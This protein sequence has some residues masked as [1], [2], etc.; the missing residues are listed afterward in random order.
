[1]FLPLILA[2][3]T[4][5]PFFLMQAT[6]GASPWW[7]IPVIQD[8]L[9]D[10]HMYLTWVGYV[11]AGIPFANN[12]GW[13]STCLRVIQS[14]FGGSLS[15]AELWLISR[16]LAALLS[17]YA[18]YF[19]FRTGLT[20]EKRAAS[21]FALAWGLAVISNAGW[22]PG[23]YSWYL[24]FA[25]LACQGILS[26][27][28]TQG[29]VKQGLVLLGSIVLASIY[30]WFLIPIGL[31][32]AVEIARNLFRRTRTWAL[33]W[34]ALTLASLGS[35]FVIMH[36]I[37]WAR[38][39]TTLD[40]FMRYGVG[41][42]HL[43]FLTTAAL[44]P[45]GWLGITVLQGRTT[46]Q[47]SQ[48]LLALYSGWLVTFFCF[49]MTPFTGIVFQNDHFRG[50]VLLL[51]W[52]HLGFLYKTHVSPSQKPSPSTRVL[53]GG[54]FFLSLA[55]SVWKATLF[56]F[57]PSDD[58]SIIQVAYWVPLTLASFL[59][60]ASGYKRLVPYIGVGIFCVLAT[61][62][63]VNIY[64]RHFHH[65]ED[66]E[67]RAH[68]RELVL[69]HVPL[70]DR[71]CIDPVRGSPIAANTPRVL[72]PSS[73]YR[74]RAEAEAEQITLLQA[75]TLGFMAQKDAHEESHLRAIIAQDQAL[76]CQQYR[77]ARSLFTRFGMTE[78]RANALIGCPAARLATLSQF[79]F[80][81]SSIPSST[82]R[83][84]FQRA[85]PWIIVMPGL[86]YLWNVPKDSIWYTTPE[87]AALIKNGLS[88][89]TK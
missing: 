26:I 28:S 29:L 80:D 68:I 71:I 1:M 48:H 11:Q 3:Y 78:A 61:V 25:I 41:F 50:F 58:L 67:L 55:V 37:P 81:H 63:S 52:I 72:L 13:Y 45:L 76:P 59:M 31:W 39:Q 64:G 75:Y 79:V 65:P 36:S 4:L 74:F 82:H 62:A 19:I 22:R 7:R 14:I 8:A 70:E 23:A 20:L 57:A 44:V 87:G 6:W 56:L 2:I 43:P 18:M 33:A 5:V 66:L 83:Q 54:I 51:T 32:G 9:F 49:E 53:L 42:T 46:T 24:P 88:E 21:L 12:I 40:V 77:W 73:T 69:S 86:N 30:P 47:P 16:W 89:E 34:G 60:L 27:S 15:T 35:V 85:C 38:I 10:S 84:V 17:V